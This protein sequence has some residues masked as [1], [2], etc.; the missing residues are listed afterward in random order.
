VSPSAVLGEAW[1]LYK[2]HWQHLLPIA[3]VIYLLL[4]LLVLLLAL[5]LGWLG[6]IAATLVSIVGTFWLQAALV[7]AVQDVKDGRADLSISETLARV[8]PHINTVTIAGLLAGIG[9]LIGF[10]LLIVPGFVL[11]TWWL[12]IIPVIMLEGAGVGDSFGRSRELV[13]GHG[14]EVFGLIILTILIV[15][16]AQIVLSLLLVPLPDAAGGFIGSV[17]SNTLFTPFLAAAW[18]LGYFH[19]RGHETAATPAVPSDAV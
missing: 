19:L 10:V 3:L 8:R 14:W 13:R 5:L 6:I 15:I 11:L 4:S 17:L 9:I 1:D 7:I 18:T 16:A 2:R 12:F